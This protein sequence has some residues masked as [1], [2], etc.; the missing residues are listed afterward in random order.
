MTRSLRIHALSL[1]LALG[2]LAAP[3]GFAA[4]QRSRSEE[5][6]T[7]GVLLAQAGRFGG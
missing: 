2:P 7:N 1:V 3:P 5:R 6:G 4:A